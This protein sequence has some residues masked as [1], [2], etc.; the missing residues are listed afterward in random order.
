MIRFLTVEE[1]RTSVNTLLDRALDFAL[2]YLVTIGGVVSAGAIARGVGSDPEVSMIVYSAVLL[3][4]V[5][6]RLQKAVKNV[7]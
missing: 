2:R 1:T 7:H 3:V 5:E 6:Y 4:H